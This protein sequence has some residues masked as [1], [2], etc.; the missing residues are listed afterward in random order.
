MPFYYPGVYPARHAFPTFGYH[1]K[2]HWLTFISQL[3]FDYASS[4]TSL[5]EPC[6][7]SRTPRWL[8]LT[9]LPPLPRLSLRLL[10]LSLPP[11]PK[12]QQ[13]A[14]P[15]PSQRRQQPSVQLE[16]Q[17]RPLDV[18]SQLRALLLLGPQPRLARHLPELLAV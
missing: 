13:R 16:P 14:P 18:L 3:A 6:P 12:L 11:R 1:P 2:L 10:P 7:T 9:R 5:H 4:F 8:S 15:R 17:P